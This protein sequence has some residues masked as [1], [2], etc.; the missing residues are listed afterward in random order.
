MCAKFG[1]CEE[2]S[3]NPSQPAEQQLLRLQGLER[4]LA[5]YAREAVYFWQYIGQRADVQADAAGGVLGGKT[6]T[7]EVI[8]PIL[9]PPRSFAATRI[10][11]YV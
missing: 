10:A 4:N 6:G 9:I 3:L 11:T 1:R 5:H 8:R 7:S 2:K